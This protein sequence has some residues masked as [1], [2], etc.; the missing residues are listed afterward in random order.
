[1]FAVQVLPAGQ[2][3]VAEHCRQTL[4]TQAGRPG[5][6]AHSAL[7]AHWRHTFVT[8]TGRPGLDAHSALLAHCRQVLA[9]A[10]D[11]TH[12]GVGSAHCVLSRHA[13][14]V[15][16]MHAGRPGVVQCESTEHC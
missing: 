9:L 14:H 7:V 10:P 8:Q 15:L 4:A 3:A 2:G 11:C 13:T 1:L 16:A 6:D 12:I 5:V